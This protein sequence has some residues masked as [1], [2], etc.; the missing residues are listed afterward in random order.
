MNWKPFLQRVL[1]LLV[2]AALLL[3][4][5]TIVVWALARVLGTMGDAPGGRVLEY[6]ALACLVLWVVDLVF[7][8]LVQ[9]VHMLFPPE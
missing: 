8:I 9:A 4:V 3:P 2:A 7:L 1:L 6:V 5:A